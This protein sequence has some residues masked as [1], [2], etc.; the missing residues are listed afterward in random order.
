MVPPMRGT[1]GNS[2][3]EDQDFHLT[4]LDNLVYCYTWKEHVDSS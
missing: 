3:I 1:G 2:T 4:F